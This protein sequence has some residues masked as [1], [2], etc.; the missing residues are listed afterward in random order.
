MA[1]STHIVKDSDH[2]TLIVCSSSG[3]ESNSVAVTAGGLSGNGGTGEEVLNIAAIKMSSATAA[4]SAKFTFDADTDDDM[5][6]LY[7]NASWGFNDTAGFTLE[8]P[9]S[10][11]Y[12]GDIRITASAATTIMLKL[13]KVEGY[14]NSK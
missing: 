11:G 6:T 13:K 14:T 8:N 5:I 12:T 4:T 10:T 1:W 2:E 7:G 9:K 3:A